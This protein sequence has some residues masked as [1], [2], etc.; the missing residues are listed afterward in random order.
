MTVS[1]PA[2]RRPDNILFGVNDWLPARLGAGL[3]LQ[4]LAFL[5][6]LLVIPEIYVRA[7]GLGHSAFLNI[8]STTLLVSALVVLL[9]VRGLRYLGAGY[10]YPLQ[11]TGA[12]LPAMY[13]VGNLPGATLATVF[14]MVWVIGLSQLVFSFF[15]MRMRN[16]FTVEVSGVAVLLIGLG[17]GHLGFG[18]VFGHGDHGDPVSGAGLFVGCLTFTTMVGCNVW[19]KNVLRLFAPL[20][21]LLVGMVAGLLLGLVSAQE[22][23]QWREMPLL[24]LPQLPVFGW[25]FESA[26]VLPYVVTGFALSLT[27]M[28]TQ[29]IAQRVSDADWVR[30]DLRA[31]ARGVRA[32]GVAHLFAGLVNALPL[33][34]SGGAVSLAAASGCTSRYLGYWTAGFLALAALV[35]HVTGAWLLLPA[36]VI[37]ALLLY[38]ATFT[39]LSGLQLIT[40][41]MLD[42]RRV[43]A[44]GMGL[45]VGTGMGTIH[46]AIQ[47]LWPDLRYVA[48][49][50]LAAGVCVAVS[51]ALL[52]RL[53]IRQGTRKSFTLAQTTLQDVT[54][55][56]EQQGRLWG[57]RHAPVRR[58]EMVGWQ[59]VE[60]LTAH[61]LV[62]P[63]CPEIQVETGFD[64]YIFTIILRYRGTLLPLAETPPSAEE[65]IASSQAELQ[66]AGYLIGRSVHHAHASRSGGVCV[67]RL[68]FEN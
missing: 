13:L 30:P 66:M 36:P 26:A 68:T 29:T 23:Q 43:L 59:V 3:A 11:A 42:N 28:G 57:T 5:G 64:E 67:L 49:S 65:L 15:I 20:L 40:S 48:L 16:V 54:D 56:L 18:E 27:S 31:L 58:A 35:P 9:Q 21:G 4:Q 34:A 6:A 51:L 8:V 24:W 37:G 7:Q 38:L 62:D 50:G 60:A 14:G 25:G 19:L 44:I 41:R 55:F 22:L 47:S 39:T 1:R 2:I 53:G 52:F 32:E 46:P 45:L 12:V 33:A 61:G 63:A 10:Y 17:L